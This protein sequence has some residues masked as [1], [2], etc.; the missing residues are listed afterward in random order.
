MNC[1]LFVATGGFGQ[2]HLHQTAVPFEESSFAIAEVIVPHSQEAVVETEPFDIF[3]P[4]VKTRPPVKMKSGPPP[5][6]P[7]Q[8]AAPHTAT[9]QPAQTLAMRLKCDDPSELL[10]GARRTMN[11]PPETYRVTKHSLNLF[12][13]GWL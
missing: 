1:D 10:N 3:N 13:R 7:S 9:R 11:S 6:F 5:L 8:A 2:H 12:D 4:I